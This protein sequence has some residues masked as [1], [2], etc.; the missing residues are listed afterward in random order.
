MKVKILLAS[1]G[2][3]L[4]GAVSVAQNTV[5][6]AEYEKWVDYVNCKRVVAFIDK[7][8]AQKSGEIGDKFKKDYTT[9]QKSKININSLNKAPKYEEIKKIIKDFPKAKLL[10]DNI[11]NKKKGFKQNWNKNQL[12][13][14]LLDLP[15]GKPSTDGNGFKGYLANATNSLKK[16]LQKQI[17][18]NLFTP[19]GESPQEQKIQTETTQAVEQS[20]PD[21]VQTVVNNTE[22]NVSTDTDTAQPAKTKYP[23]AIWIFWLC[24]IGLAVALIYYFR[25]EIKSYLTQRF[26]SNTKNTDYF[27]D[28][29][30]E[31]TIVPYE[32]LKLENKKLM[33]FIK[34]WEAENAKLRTENQRLINKIRELEQRNTETAP[35]TEGSELPKSNKRFA[36]NIIDGIFN[37][38]TEQPNDYSVFELSLLSQNT[39]SFTVYRNAYRRVLAAPEFIEGCEKQILSDSPSDLE[40]EKGEA[41]F[42]NEN[43]KWQITKK[44]KIKF[45]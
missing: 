41:R 18:E 12:I 25:K 7:K 37:R 40:I 23:F 29:K 19:K 9:R 17:P 11:N 31:D 16:D 24:F 35:K 32:E 38:V 20:M 26:N 44:A 4:C 42:N 6:Q 28:E 27:V 1:V 10:A 8:I 2:I 45:I 33:Q 5:S 21:T 39:A 34:Q 30:K 22:T 3:I 15:T 13:S 14:Y 43:A 36:A